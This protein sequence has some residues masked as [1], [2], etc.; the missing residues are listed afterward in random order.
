MMPC[1]MASDA[2]IERMH[3]F[4]RKEGRKEEINLFHSPKKMSKEVFHSP[5]VQFPTT[6]ID[7]VDEALFWK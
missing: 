6:R 5:F 3:R 4:R 7:L 2:M 1:L